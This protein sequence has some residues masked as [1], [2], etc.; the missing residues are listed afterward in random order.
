MYA[1]VDYLKFVW[2]ANEV[3]AMAARKVE[4]EALIDHLRK[5]DDTITGGHRWGTVY[6]GRGN[7]LSTLDVYGPISYRFCLSCSAL[8]LEAITRVDTRWTLYVDTD[9]KRMDALYDDT[10][11]LNTRNRNISRGSARV[12][13]KAEGRDGGGDRIAVGSLKSNKYASVYQKPGEYTAL[14]VKL[15]GDALDGPKGETKRLIK[16]LGGNVGKLPASFAIAVKRLAEAHAVEVFGRSIDELAEFV[17]K[18]YSLKHND[19][20]E[21]RLHTCESAFRELALEDQLMM[22][23]QLEDIVRSQQDPLSAQADATDDIPF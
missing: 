15:S 21:H 9:T 13:A 16:L 4:V 23:E 7:W 5:E 20:T 22:L 6:D 10:R 2:H 17:D 14:E 12:R 8:Y 18:D 3:E 1:T 19:L 11:A